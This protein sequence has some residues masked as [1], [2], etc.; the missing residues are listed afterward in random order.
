MRISGSELEQWH[1]YLEEEDF[2]DFQELSQRL[3]DRRETSAMR[4]GTAFHEFLEHSQACEYGDDIELDGFRFVLRLDAELSL[5]RIR[6]TK[7]ERTYCID[8]HQVILC[9]TVDTLHGSSV[10]DHKLTE[11]LDVDR[12]LES[13]QWRAYL[14]IFAANRFTYNVFEAIDRGMRDGLHE[15]VIKELHQITCHRY[16]A[17]EADVLGYLTSYARFLREHFPERMVDN[18]PRYEPLTF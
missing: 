1:L 10:G 2:I 7:G 6:E 4:A 5:P 12:Y 14:S 17:M 13:L 3:Q 9:G 16:P 18:D 15:R 8:G 11:D